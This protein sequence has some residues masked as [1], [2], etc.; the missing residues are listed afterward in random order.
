MCSYWLHELE[1]DGLELRASSNDSVLFY[2]GCVTYIHCHPHMC[3][4]IWVRSNFSQFKL[5]I[6][7]KGG[8]DF[9]CLA[10]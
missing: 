4:Y 6:Y 7:K 10:Y 2:H 9:C 5:P 3:T 1:D 8:S